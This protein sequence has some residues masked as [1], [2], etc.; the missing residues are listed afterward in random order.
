MKTLGGI[1]GRKKKQRVTI[2]FQSVITITRYHNNYQQ[3]RTR[4]CGGRGDRKKL[5][6]PSSEPRPKNYD[7]DVIKIRGVWK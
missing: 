3:L 1:G 5:D 2:V 4:G 6:V 7:N